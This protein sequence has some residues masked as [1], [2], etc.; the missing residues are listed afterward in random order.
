MKKLAIFAIY[1]KWNL[2]CALGHFQEQALVRLIA[3][4]N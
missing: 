1:Q 3:E 4:T 2:V